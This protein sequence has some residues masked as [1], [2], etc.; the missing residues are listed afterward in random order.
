VRY[1]Y[2]I[3]DGNGY[4]D[5]FPH[6]A[7]VTGTVEE[8][9]SAWL[10]SVE[11]EG[12]AYRARVIMNGEI[13]EERNFVC[14]VSQSRTEPNGNT[15]YIVQCPGGQVTVERQP[16]GDLSGDVQPGYVGD[17]DLALQRAFDVLRKPVAS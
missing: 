14:I 7:D 2:Q 5:F 3:D 8:S 4:E 11:A 1:Q 9:P 13:I 17:T 10:A 12:T 15:R 16:G 6:E